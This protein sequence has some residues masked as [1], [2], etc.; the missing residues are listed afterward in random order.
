MTAGYWAVM[1][2]LT[3]VPPAE[4]GPPGPLSDKQ[5]HFLAYLILSFLL[6]TTL[7]LIFPGR[8]R[9][10]PLALIATGMAYGGVDELTQ[11]LVGRTCDIYDWFADVA[12]VGT[13]AR[14]IFCFQR[15]CWPADR[16]VARAVAA[17]K[18]APRPASTSSRPPPATPAA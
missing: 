5:L 6:G 7:V 11:P 14:L 1:F 16:R 12:G 10:I 9:W 13:S 8:R 17:D 3:H 18:V 15:L 4:L 2:K